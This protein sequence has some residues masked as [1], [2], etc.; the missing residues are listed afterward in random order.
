MFKKIKDRI[1]LFIKE[2]GNFLT[3]LLIPLIGLILIVVEVLP[4]PIKYISFL[5]TI[6]YW[7]FYAAGTAEKINENIKKNFNKEK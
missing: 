5:K 1:L 6:E 7:L 4:I 3:N 2:I